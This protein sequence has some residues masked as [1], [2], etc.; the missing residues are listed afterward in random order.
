LLSLI[1]I[2]I[3]AYFHAAAAFHIFATPL[4]SAFTIDCRYFSPLIDAIDFRRQLFR[5]RF[6]F[7]QPLYAARRCRYSCRFT[8]RRY[9]ACQLHASA[10]S[11]RLMPLLIFDA[12]SLFISALLLHF[13]FRFSFRFSIFFFRLF[14]DAAID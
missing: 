9:F 1:I 12:F 3:A 2:F 10:F 8:C 14:H 13:H 4:A 6:R 11:A 5:C 7:R